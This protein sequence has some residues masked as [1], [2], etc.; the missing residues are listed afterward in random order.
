MQ[1]MSYAIHGNRKK[2]G[3]AEDDFVK[4]L[5]C[6]IAFVRSN[7][8]LCEQR[9]DRGYIIQKRHGRPLASFVAVCTGK[10]KPDTIVPYGEGNLVGKDLKQLYEFLAKI[11]ANIDLVHANFREIS[12]IDNPQSP[13]DN[14]DRRRLRRNRLGSDMA[15]PAFLI[16]QR[17][18][19]VNY[20]GNLA[21]KIVG[22]SYIPFAL[23][24]VAFSLTSR[25]H[26]TSLPDLHKQHRNVASLLRTTLS[27]VSHE[28]FTPCHSTDHNSLQ[29]F[30][31]FKKATRS[32]I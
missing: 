17:Y 22:Y 25:I 31:P 29:V 15:E 1:V 8:I 10:V 6:G 20:R 28:R 19:P 5:R 13:V 27:C 26:N 14:I 12:G 32:T 21:P 18:D 30:K 23:P 4:I 7:N 11:V 24:L 2:P 9:L 3:V 16:V